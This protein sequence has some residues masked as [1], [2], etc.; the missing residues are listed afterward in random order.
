M[1]LAL[2]LI[3][4]AV[5]HS[6]PPVSSGVFPA[7]AGFFTWFTPLPALNFCSRALQQLPKCHR[8]Y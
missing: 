3:M 1:L 7:I 6:F 8:R 4:L 2:L 5:R